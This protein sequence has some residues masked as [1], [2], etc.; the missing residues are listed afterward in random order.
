MWIVSVRIR[1]VNA[2][3][4]NKVIVVVMVVNNSIMT[5]CWWTRKATCSYCCRSFCYDHFNIPVR[6]V[7]ETKKRIE[8][9][10]IVYTPNTS[11]TRVSDSV[12][13]K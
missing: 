12:L 8:H 5:V 1:T 3:M 4:M 9:I 11:S 2:P 13:L 6:N 7:L 10:H